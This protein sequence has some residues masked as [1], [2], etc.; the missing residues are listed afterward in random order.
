M[1]FFNDLWNPAVVWFIAGLILLLLELAVPGLVLFFFGIGAWIAAILYLI[2]GIGIDMQLLVF[3]VSSLLLLLSLRRYVQK[4][5]KGKVNGSG[6]SDKESLIGEKAV[7]ISAIVP[8]ARGKV[9]IHGTNWSA[10]SDTELT[11]GT[12]VEITGQKNLTLIVKSLL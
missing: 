4:L 9:E 10:E 1:D 6:I 2:F 5:F 11:P 3:V 12:T 7:V 8:S